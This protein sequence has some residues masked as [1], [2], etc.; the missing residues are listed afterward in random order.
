VPTCVGCGPDEGSDAS[1]NT[2]VDEQTTAE[3]RS[4]S[5]AAVA[6]LG[7]RCVELAGIS[8]TFTQSLDGKTGSLDDVRYLLD[9]IAETVPA[10]I[11]EDYEVV[12]AS[13]GK[14]GEALRD[15]DFGFGTTQN[16]DDL[17]KI[18][19]L[20][21]TLDEGKVRGAARSVEDWARANC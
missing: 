1:R 14:I 10:E 5:E 21:A 6:V 7:V 4:A 8:A 9:S 16:P 19:K 18:Q 20:A 17:R 15:V 2:V 11:E 3:T 13:F 12:V